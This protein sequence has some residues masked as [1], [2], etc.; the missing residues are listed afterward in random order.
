MVIVHSNEFSSHV[1]R[2]GE[3]LIPAGSGQR[4]IRSFRHVFDLF[5]SSLRAESPKQEVSLI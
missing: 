3:K 1:T 2:L 5:R 4:M